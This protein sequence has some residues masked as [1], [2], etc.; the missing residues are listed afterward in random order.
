MTGRLPDLSP[1]D[2]DILGAVMGGT[3]GAAD[4]RDLVTRRPARHRG[5]RG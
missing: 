5:I 2:L 3:K 1:D 4:G